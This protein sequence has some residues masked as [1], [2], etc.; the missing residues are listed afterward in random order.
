MSNSLRNI[1]LQEV[2]DKFPK[3]DWNLG[4]V[5]RE[6]VI[7]PLSKLGDDLDQYIANAKASLDVQNICANPTKYEDEL[8]EWVDRLGISPPETRASSG[9]VRITKESPDRMV[10]PAGTQFSWNDEV[11]VYTQETYVATK[12]GSDQDLDNRLEYVSYGGSAFSVDI[13]VIGYV[14]GGSVASGAP[15]NWSG[16]PDDVYDIH[17]GSAISGGVSSFNVHEK[18]AKILDALTP[19]ALS[20]E[21]CIRKALRLNFPDYVRDVVVGEKDVKKPYAVSL[22]VK[23]VNSFQQFDVD[24]KLTDGKGVVDGC[25]INKVTELFGPDGASYNFSADYSDDFGDTGSTAT[26]ITKNLTLSGMFKARVVGFSEYR[27]IN[28]WLVRAAKSTPFEFN[29]KMPVVGMVSMI[30]SAPNADYSSARSDIAEFVSS[31]PLDGTSTDSDIAKILSKYD[32]DQ[33]GAVVYSVSAHWK[34]EHTVKTMFGGISSDALR[35]YTSIPVAFYSN[36][37]LVEIKNA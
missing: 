8:D 6:L 7:E 17:V 15:L 32:A 35:H 25:G 36:D 22:Y 10:I 34:N 28:A 29:L 1:L 37:N 23:P 30:C 13:P 33:Y 11:V 21:A 27:N 16:A 5:V 24:V 4:S 31:L 20:G 3:L 19:D 18:A 12:V 14:G 2:R 9:T 26:L